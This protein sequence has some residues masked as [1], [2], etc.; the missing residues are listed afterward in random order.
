MDSKNNPKILFLRPFWDNI[1][2]SVAHIKA[3]L[4]AVKGFGSL[5]VFQNGRERE[6]LRIIGD[7]NP[8]RKYGALLEKVYDILYPQNNL[9][10]IQ[11]PKESWQEEIIKQIQDAD[12]VIVH[13]A[14]KGGINTE[15]DEIRPNQ[16]PTPL[17]DYGINPVHESG[18]GYGLLRE[19]D[20]CKQ[21]NSLNK[22]IV[23]IPNIFYPRILEI[24]RIL[25]TTQAGQFYRNTKDGFV[26]LTPK[27][28]ARDQSL[29]ILENVNSIIPY[30]SFGGT[31]F[32]FHIRQALLSFPQLPQHQQSNLIINIPSNP[33][34]LPPDD[35]LKNIRYTPIKRLTK[36]PNG[37]I[38]ELS[39]GEV[40]Q[41]YPD[42]ENEPLECPSCHSDSKFMF[43]YKYGL[44][45]KLTTEHGVYMRCQYCG[46]DDYL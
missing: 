9:I 16:T 29:G 18:T 19:L 14:P 40:K 31:I 45:P 21:A 44:E 6:R 12:I 17:F 24:L 13:L 2:V 43:W 23:L 46:H 36:I 1:D 27:L 22:V 41:I 37:E 10:L 15:F 39:F 8:W 25:K 34:K 30:Q 5:I 20:Y 26:S 28:S 35:C 3:T 32:N 42:L 4:K 11:A 33:V 7:I 38:V